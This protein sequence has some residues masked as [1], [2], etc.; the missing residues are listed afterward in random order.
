MKIIS[1]MLKS[2]FPIF[3]GAV[4]FFV[5]ILC[6]T[7]FFMNLWN[8]IS[9]G[10]TTKDI[11]LIL[12]YYIPKTVWYS[13][14]IAMLFATAYMLSDFYARN[15]LLVIFASG[16]SLFRFTIPLLFVAIAMSFLMFFF[17]DLIVV[18]TYT[19]KVHL[20]ESVLQT[21]KSLNNDKIVLMADEGRLIYKADFYDDS[22]KRLYS[23][24]FIVRDEQKNLK[25]LIYSD[26]A[27]W[28]NEKWVL[29]KSVEYKNSEQGIVLVDVEEDLL[30]LFIEPP[31]TFRN[32]TISVEEVNTKQARQ[33]IKHLEKAGLPSAEEKSV[34]YKKYSFP[35]VVFIVVFLAIGLSGKTRKN[36]LI[37]SL[38]LS[39]TAVV[40]FYVTQMVTMLMAKFQAIPPLFGAWFP[41][42]LFILISSFLL[43][44]AKT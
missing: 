23:V 16:I 7:D 28:I 44:Y 4:M 31:E 33:Y 41:V 2:F 37:V 30:D 9:K 12:L 26:V 35:F 5:L 15:E 1:Y 36:V 42:M 43:K 14:P 40:L 20:Q 18:P 17:E 39:V 32:N 21:E 19:K 27:S 38:A 3:L 10:V 8:Y 22:V 13:I 34:Y 6:L 29:S 24:Y 11:S 25:A